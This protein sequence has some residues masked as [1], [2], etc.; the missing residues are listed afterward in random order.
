MLK[1][2]LLKGLPN[3]YLF[4]SIIGSLSLMLIRHIAFMSMNSTQAKRSRTYDM[5]L[6]SSCSWCAV[7]LSP[8]GDAGVLQRGGLGLLRVMCYSFY[9]L[10]LISEKNDSIFQAFGYMN[11]SYT[12]RMPSLISFINKVR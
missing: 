2:A 10:G 9:G 3:C 8:Q 4:C 11:R 6:W 12:I 1:L 5:Q 7:V